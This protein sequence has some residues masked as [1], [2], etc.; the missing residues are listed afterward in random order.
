[1]PREEFRDPASG[2]LWTL[3]VLLMVGVI[4]GNIRTIALPAMVTA[5]IEEDT[6]DRANGLVGTASGVSFLVTSVISG[7]LVALGG[8]FWVLVAALV[9]LALALLHLALVRVPPGR[10]SQAA[11]SGSDRR[12]DLRG[13]VRVIGQ[14]PGLP[15]LIVFSAFNN[16]L[17][18]VFMALLDAYGLSMMSV[19]GWGFVFIPFMT[20]GSGARWIG[21]WFGTGAAR[22]LAVVFILTGVIGLI[23]TAVALGS[24]PYRRLS[25]RYL[26]APEARVG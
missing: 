19:Q 24:C 14:V 21:S 6:R 5:L 18:G 3:I 20:D 17:G 16:L 11:A 22:G 10:A 9:V 1:M 2:W 4:T 12:V 8:M 26:T 25:G 15:A 7:L 23:A 13:T